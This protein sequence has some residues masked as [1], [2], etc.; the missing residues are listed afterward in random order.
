MIFLWR[1][2]WGFFL[3]GMRVF[4]LTVKLS[5]VIYF[6]IYYFDFYYVIIL[7][8]NYVKDKDIIDFKDFYFVEFY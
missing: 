1:W 7:L 4:I 5:F 2:C 8:F 6:K 3:R